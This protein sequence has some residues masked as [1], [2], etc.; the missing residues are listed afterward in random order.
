MRVKVKCLETGIQEEIHADI[1]VDASG[2]SSKS[3]EWLREYEIEVQEEKVRINLFYATKMFKLKENEEL[4][5]C[6]MLMSQVSLTIRMVF[7]FKRLRIIVILLLSAGMQVRKHHKQ[8]RNFIIL[9]KIY[10]SPM[11]QIS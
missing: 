1:V 11:L 8:M 5:C 2:F 3:I 9:L 7:L 4:D 10:Q 6:N